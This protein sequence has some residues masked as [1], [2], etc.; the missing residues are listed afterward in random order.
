MQSIYTRR[1]GGAFVVCE[2]DIPLIAAAVGVLADASVNYGVAVGG[3]CCGDF[4]KFTRLAKPYLSPPL[5]R[6]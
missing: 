4:H 1:N 5:T 2:H 3:I 6:G